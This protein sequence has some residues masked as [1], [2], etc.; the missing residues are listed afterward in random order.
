MLAENRLGCVL[1]GVDCYC[2]PFDLKDFR[3]RDCV[4]DNTN[5]ECHFKHDVSRA[6]AANYLYSYLLDNDLSNVI[7]DDEAISDFCWTYAF[8]IQ[9]R[10]DMGKYYGLSEEEYNI[11]SCDENGYQKMLDNWSKKCDEMALQYLNLI[12][13]DK[14]AIEFA[15]KTSMLMNFEV[16][17]NQMVIECYEESYSELGPF[18]YSEESNVLADLL[19]EEIGKIKVFDENLE[20]VYSQIRE[21]AAKVS[22][23]KGIDIYDIKQ[24]SG[25]VIESIK[26]QL[27]SK[28]AYK[29]NLPTR[30]NGTSEK[31][32]NRE[33]YGLFLDRICPSE[34]LAGMSKSNSL[35]LNTFTGDSDIYKSLG[36]DYKVEYEMKSINER[37]NER[38]EKSADRGR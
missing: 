22:E 7:L 15:I 37:A 23:E 14:K 20:S 6:F 11:L 2:W 36:L 32:K 18:L 34:F 28:V 1:T 8:N 29:L 33:L 13:E 31:I 5:Q 3:Y 25:M 27:T 19:C 35:Q 16:D 12:Q 17:S 30:L 21:V 38:E 24:E 9:E 26:E 4:M 10:S